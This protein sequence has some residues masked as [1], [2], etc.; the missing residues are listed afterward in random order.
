[1]NENMVADALAATGLNSEHPVLWS[2][3]GSRLYG[4]ET[5]SSDYDLVLATEGGHHDCQRQ[6]EDY[7]IHIEPLPLFLTRALDSQPNEVDILHSHGLHMLDF[8]YAPFIAELRFETNRYVWRQEG[9]AIRWLHAIMRD[10]KNPRRRC[11]LQ[12][13][14]HGPAQSR[15][16][17][18]SV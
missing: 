14:A 16:V 9:H 17:H 1:M 7:D 10:G 2:V 4:L 3:S 11:K 8:S 15:V 6:S 13:P 5:A 12:V 18:P